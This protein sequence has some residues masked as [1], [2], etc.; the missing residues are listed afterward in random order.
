M[1]VVVVVLFVICDLEP[2]VDVLLEPADT[3]AFVSPALKPFDTVVEF[4]PEFRV[5]PLELEVVVVVVID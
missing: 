1:V 5:D 2:D 4:V 3:L